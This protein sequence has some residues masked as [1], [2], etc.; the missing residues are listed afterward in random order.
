M[1]N[2]LFNPG[3]IEGNQRGKVTIIQNSG[4]QPA[5]FQLSLVAGEFAEGHEVARTP[6]LRPILVGPS[7]KQQ[8]GN[9]NLIHKVSNLF[10]Q[11]FE[12]LNAFRRQTIVTDHPT[13]NQ[14]L[15]MRILGSENGHGARP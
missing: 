14:E 2:M 6:D 12:F 11:P 4:F 3:R 10:V 9:I 7:N 13:G 5:S 8:I 15:G 1:V